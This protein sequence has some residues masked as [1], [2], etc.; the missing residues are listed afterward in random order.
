MK[1]IFK[2]IKYEKYY[3]DILPYLK[4]EKNQ[5]YF[6]V[7]LTLGASIF[8]ALFA[9]NPT[10]S[11]IARLRKEVADSKLV[12]QK[13]SQKI[14]NLSLLSRAYENIE[15]DV[16][17]V[18]DAVPKYAE[19]PILIA[20][21]QAVAQNSEIILSNLSVAP[22]NLTATPS[23][24]SSSFVFEFSAQGNYESLNKFLS[25]VTNMQR[26]VSI[27]SFTIAKDSKTQILDVAIKGSAFYKK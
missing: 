23:T 16:S 2:N 9:I 26:V 19:A 25:D 5:Q 12:E 27:D 1:K 20:Q 22:I 11:T 7:I 15:S 17:Y 8:F 18:L 4:K 21:V 14:S 24:M 13:L 3:K 10:L 6:A